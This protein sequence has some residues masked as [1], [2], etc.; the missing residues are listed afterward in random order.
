MTRYVN[1]T[2]AFL[3]EAAEYGDYY[4]Y[5]G[6]YED[7]GEDPLQTF[8]I[9]ATS[10]VTRLPWPRFLV[11]LGSALPLILCGV[12]SLNRRVSLPLDDA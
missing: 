2:D 9:Y 8:I 3:K 6:E 5:D 7:S 12:I 11:S 1:C 10:V 4:D